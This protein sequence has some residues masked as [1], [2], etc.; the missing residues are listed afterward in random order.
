MWKAI[1]LFLAGIGSF[2]RSF[3]E[4]NSARMIEEIG[5]IAY[6]VVKRIELNHKPGDDKFKL[7][8]EALIQEL[9]E[10]GLGYTISILNTAIE[11]AVDLL[12]ERGE[13]IKRQMP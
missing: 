2:L 13:E 6:E 7:A 4:S 1:R 8:Q 11:I 12:R 5:D 10:R 9:T 3:L